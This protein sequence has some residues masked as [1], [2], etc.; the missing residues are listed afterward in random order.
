MRRRERLQAFPGDAGDVE[1]VDRIRL[2]ALAG[3]PTRVGGQVPGRSSPSSREAP[4]GGDSQRAPVRQAPKSRSL[5]GVSS[6]SYP[7]LL[8]TL[9]LDHGN[10]R[11]VLV[12][13]VQSHD[14]FFGRVYRPGSRSSCAEISPDEATAVGQQKLMLMLM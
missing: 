7:P 11:P 12:V 13:R 4:D 10:L 14:Q 6:K 5:P 8:S 3:A 1:R 9:L 2:A